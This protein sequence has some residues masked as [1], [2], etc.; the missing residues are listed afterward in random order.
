MGNLFTRRAIA[1]LLAVALAI[2]AVVA[3]LNYVR[4]VESQAA[5]EADL[6]RGYVATQRIE[7]GTLADT[8][9]QLEAIREEQ[10]PRELLAPDAVT[11]LTLI[12][13]RTVQEVILPGDQILTTRFSEPGQSANVLTIPP[14]HQAM[15]FAV[16][17]PDGVAGFL[18]EG[19]FVSI[20]SVADATGAQLDDDGEPT[21]E[22]FSDQIAKYVLQDV[23]ILAIGRR[24]AP[25]EQAPA[26][27]T[28]EGGGGVLL[29]VAVTPEEAERLVFGEV[30]TNLWLTLLP[31]DERDPVTTPGVTADSFFND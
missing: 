23:E 27:G 26:G 6:V 4:N 25:T 5:S 17:I 13:G 8:A 28:E 22:T 9:I 20:I 14:D 31:E 24:T 29:T 18:R 12:G 16:G 30:N 11:D 15:S 10:I 7:P 3:V 2:L 19:D 1:F 21:D